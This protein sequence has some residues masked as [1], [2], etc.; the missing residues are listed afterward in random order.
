[1][2]LTRIRSRLW[3]QV[4][5]AL[6][7]WFVTVVTAVLPDNRV[8]FSL[9]GAMLRPFILKAGK[10]FQVGRAVSLLNT[11]QLEVGDNVWIAHGVWLNALGRI[12]IDDE[13]MLGPYV[14]M[15][16]LQHEFRD[17]SVRFGGSSAAPI[18]IGRGSWL[19][20]HVSVAMGTDIGAGTL[21]A[22]NSA[23]SGNVPAGMIVGGV[24]ARVIKERIDSPG[25]VMTRSDLLGI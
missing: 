22:A 19:A 23:V 20:A 12:T 24:P 1:V 7:V 11:D 13:V 5:W 17:A 3:Q 10:G 8:T 14:A 15:I 16:A 6:P 4:R 2:S 25:S 18:R 21:V 9:R